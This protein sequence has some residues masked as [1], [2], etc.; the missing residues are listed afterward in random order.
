[1]FQEYDYVFGVVV[2]EGQ[3]VLKLPYNCFENPWFVAQKFLHDNDLTEEYF[4]LL[5]NLIKNNIK[6][7]VPLGRG[8]TSVE[9]WE[10]FTG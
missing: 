5:A 9:F 10:P 7:S 1:V 8:R 6:R 2:Y 4:G 3:P